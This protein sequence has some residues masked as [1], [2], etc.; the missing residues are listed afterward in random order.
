MNRNE[1]TLNLIFSSKEDN[2][3]WNFKTFNI[4]TETGFAEDVYGE[5]YSNN[6]NGYYVRDE[7]YP[8]AVIVIKPSFVDMGKVS[9]GRD[10][11]DGYDYE[12]SSWDEFPSVEITAND[13]S[14]SNGDDITEEEFMEIAGVSPEELNE[15][16]SKI[17]KYA[18]R[19]FEAYLEEN[20]DNLK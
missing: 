16:K 14:Y 2:D 10:R 18:S 1:Q 6:F 3:S 12:T 4:D 17:I 7:Y 20:Y 19:E 5:F 8:E 15:I 9:T 11:Y 13:F